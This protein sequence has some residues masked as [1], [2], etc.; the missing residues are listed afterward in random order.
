MADMYPLLKPLTEQL[1][2]EVIKYGILTVSTEQYQIVCNS[3]IRFAETAWVDSYSPELMTSYQ[4]FLDQR[5]SAGGICKEYRRFQIRVIRMLSSLADDGQMDF[6][7]AK[8]PV[9]K[10]PVSDELAELVEKIL[11]TYQISDK[12]KKDLRLRRGISCGMPLSKDWFLKVL[13][14]RL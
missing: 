14:T 10:Y 5:V 6:S 3:I 8:C 9:R 11:D 7:S 1:M 12:T 4:E 2:K 13:A